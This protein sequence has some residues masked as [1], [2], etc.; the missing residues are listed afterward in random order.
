[1]FVC[2]FLNKV[3]SLDFF[4][5]VNVIWFKFCELLMFVM[6]DFGGCVGGGVENGY[7]G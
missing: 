3:V 7:G 4:L 6:F 5:L 2:M 1:M